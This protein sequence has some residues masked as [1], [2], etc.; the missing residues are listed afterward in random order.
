MRRNHTKSK[1][2]TGT[3]VSHPAKRFYKLSK[4]LV[5]EKQVGINPSTENNKAVFATFS[6]ASR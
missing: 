3:S 1:L 6:V 5:P 4:Y 2:L